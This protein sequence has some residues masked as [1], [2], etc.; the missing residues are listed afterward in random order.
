MAM[1]MVTSEDGGVE[2]FEQ[3]GVE[4]FGVVV[5]AEPGFVGGLFGVEGRSGGGRRVGNGICGRSGLRFGGLWGGRHVGTRLR[6]DIHEHRSCRSA[7]HKRC[8]T[9]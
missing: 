1:I 5:H 4:G 3:C 7:S 8:P 6:W 9:P 2:L